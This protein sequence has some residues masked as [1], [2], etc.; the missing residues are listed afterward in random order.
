MI[1]TRIRPWAQLLTSWVPL[2]ELT[3]QSHCCFYPQEGLAVVPASERCWE[4]LKERCRQYS[5][6]P[7]GYSKPTQLFSLGGGVYRYLNHYY[8]HFWLKPSLTVP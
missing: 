6:A 3:C 2:G 4:D 5:T 1:N 7:G 8:Y